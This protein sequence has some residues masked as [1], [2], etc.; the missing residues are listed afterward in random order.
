M[1]KSKVELGQGKGG[2]LV[3]EETLELEDSS[4]IE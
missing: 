2:E 1:R 4:R 3:G